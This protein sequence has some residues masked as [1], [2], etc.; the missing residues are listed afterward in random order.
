MSSGKKK[1]SKI[2]VQKVQRKQVQRIYECQLS[3]IGEKN[4]YPFQNMYT[5]H[6]LIPGNESANRAF[7]QRDIVVRSNLDENL[8]CTSVWI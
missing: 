7:P 6:T 8:N 3:G 2:L 1:I 5:P 4:T